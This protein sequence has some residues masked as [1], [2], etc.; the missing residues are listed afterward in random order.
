M[1]PNKI[2]GQS[3]YEFLNRKYQQLKNVQTKPESSNAIETDQI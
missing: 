2:N 3:P 1:D